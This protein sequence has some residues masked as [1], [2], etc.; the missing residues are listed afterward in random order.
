M[1]Y[2]ALDLHVDTCTQYFW[3][4]SED[5]ASCQQRYLSVIRR[6][7]AV[8]SAMFTQRAGVGSAEA[9]RAGANRARIEAQRF[10]SEGRSRS[11]DRGQSREC[12]GSEMWQCHFIAPPCKHQALSTLCRC[13]SRYRSSI[14]S[15]CA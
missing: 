6:R 7:V 4:A 5:E 15:A 8:A 3:S 11:S 12:G 13:R 10:G 2:F 1:A 9:R 14:R